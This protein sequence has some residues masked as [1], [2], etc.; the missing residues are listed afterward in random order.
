[1]L[2]LLYFGFWLFASVVTMNLGLLKFVMAL[3]LLF[4]LTSLASC[5]LLSI[6]VSISEALKSSMLSTVFV[7]V[8]MIFVM[9]NLY[10]TNPLAAGFEVNLLFFFAFL[11][12]TKMSINL[13]VKGAVVVSITNLFLVYCL[14]KMGFSFA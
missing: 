13:N 5:K 4:T 11:L 3:T 7:G 2:Y 10:N 12:A 1:M 14:I 6:T 8:L 9:Q